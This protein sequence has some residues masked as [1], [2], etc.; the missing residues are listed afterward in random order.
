MRAL[1]QSVTPTWEGATSSVTGA[2][3][4]HSASQSRLTLPPH[5]HAAWLG[6]LSGAAGKGAWQHAKRASGAQSPRPAPL[7]SAA[8]ALAP[9]MCSAQQPP[10]VRAQLPFPAQGG[11][12]YFPP[13][14]RVDLPLPARGGAE[15]SVQPAVV[16]VEQKE[17][18]AAGSHGEGG[19]RKLSITLIPCMPG[20]NWYKG[21]GPAMCVRS[22]LNP[23]AKL[24]CVS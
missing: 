8:E 17:R 5:I 14:V 16:D 10:T 18:H 19:E 6:K 2:S 13:T 12:E 21:A 20:S 24:A 4:V 11:A 23:R 22:C 15:C 7:H 9:N 3:S 1:P